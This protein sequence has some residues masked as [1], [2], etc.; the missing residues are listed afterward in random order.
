[1]KPRNSITLAT[2]GAALFAC[3]AAH[4]QTPTDKLEIVKPTQP[5]EQKTPR[6]EMSPTEFDFGEILQGAPAVREFTVK[7]TGT[8]PLTLGVKSSCGCTVASKPKSP[9]DPGESS[10]FTIS[11][12]TKHVGRANKKV[13]VTTN[14]PDKQSV[15]IDVKGQVNA[16]FRGTPSDRVVFTGLEKSSQEAQ[17]VR[18][19]NT[20][21]RPIKLTLQEGQNFGNFTVDF[22]EVESGKV[23]DVTV[24]TKPPLK[25]GTNHA[26][27]ML[28][29]DDKEVP[30]LRVF[31]SARVEPRALVTPT[32]LFVRPGMDQPH[33]QNLRIQYRKDQPLKITGVEPSIE[34]IKYEILPESPPR[35]RSDM[36]Y[37]QIR[38]TLPAYDDL[39]G[40]GVAIDIL[41]DASSPEY[42]KFHVDVRKQKALTRGRPRPATHKE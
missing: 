3:S 18:L 2:F 35:R 39:P 27:I 16:V 26:N 32:V 10:S 15:V 4:A 20:L 8:A 22:K 7:N 6:L 42:Q 33:S 38:L 28:D 19:E 34:A 37:Q 12:N 31:V 23:Y 41:T 17:T 9:L 24:A 1:M 13:T 14:D 29:T 36:A 30:P 25:E 21:D 5:T 11:Y 40:E